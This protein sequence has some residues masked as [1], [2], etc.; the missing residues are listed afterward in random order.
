[1]S[2]EQPGRPAGHSTRTGPW[3]TLRT[4]LPHLWPKGRPGLRLRV[5]VAMAL[6]TA[7]KL[8]NVSVPFLYKSAV[9]ALDV[10]AASLIAL[11]IL[12]IVAYGGARIAAQA[13]GELR[14]AVF[15]KVAQAAVR[16]VGL[17]VFNHLHALS[18]RF[19]L[20][21]Q[22]GGLSRAIER[23]TAGIQFVLSFTLFNILPTL[24]EIG[25][26]CGILLTAYSAGFAAITLVT[27]IGYIAYTLFVTEWR[28]KH[29]REMNQRDQE[30]NTKAIDSLLNYE[31]VKY[32][33]NEAH[34]AARYDRALARYEQAAVK[35]Q[36]SLSMLNIGQGL[37]IAVG[38][39]GVMLLAGQGVAAG[40]LTL[41]DFV[42]VNTFLIQLYMPLNFLGF[43]YREMKQSL[44]DM[45]RMFSLLDVHEEVRDAPDAKPLAEGPGEVRFEN[46]GFGYDP[47]RPILDSVSFTVPAG[48]KVAIVGPSGAGK[49][50]IA[51]LLFRFYDPTGGRV[52]VDGQDIRA[53]TQLS[54][55][56]VI[57]VVPQDTVLFNDS[58]R[59][60][61]RY[62][63]P[64]ASD[65]E[66]EQAARLARIDR[67]IAELPDG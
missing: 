36:V 48:H 56:A 13:F 41:G 14:D 64:D 20:E 19:H 58:I 32:F 53:V 25:L 57:G 45:E 49:S 40:K 7:A 60:N 54:L 47:R 24:L 39:I 2:G 37:I 51:R 33:G 38:L 17:A 35:N 29:R 50:T 27:I 55:R 15:A 18:L 30:A 21:R 67:F 8:V 59:Y 1:M 6:L 23:G 3:A 66:V 10:K 46:V 44:T 65:A 9:D 61:I 43:V 31:T 62:G 34:E 28:T 52:L 4:L 5:V 22:T 42:L 16:S 63:R 12:V 26:V 11:P